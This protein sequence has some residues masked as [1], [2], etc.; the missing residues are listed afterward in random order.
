MN[1]RNNFDFMRF[2]AATLVVFSHSFPLIGKFDQE[3]FMRWSGHFGGGALGVAIFF[4]MSGYLVTASRQ[5]SANALQFLLKRALR[6]FPALAVVVLLSVFVLGP[7]LTTLPLGTYLLH[8][9]TRGY[10]WNI[11]L[12]LHFTLPGVFSG[13]P[14]SGPVNGSLWTLPIEA[15]MYVAVA[16]LG[17]IGL[18]RRQWLSIGLVALVAL[19]A[20]VLS[21]QEMQKIGLLKEFIKFGIYFFIGAT[22]YVF[23]RMIPWRAWIAALLLIGWIASFHTPY[24]AYCMF[25]A[26]SYCTL[27]IARSSWPPLANFGRYGDFSYGIYIYSFPVQQTLVQLFGPTNLSPLQLFFM[28]QAI[29]LTCAA[30][31]W[32]LIEKPALRLKRRLPAPATGA[33]AA[34]ASLPD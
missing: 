16:I 24:G 33:P 17:A 18:L 29:A 30:I 25:V 8:P 22:L 28:A 23:D 21:D 2:V 20:Y 6:I 32:H 34:T 12:W 14:Y 3:P 19:Y 7:L 26:V 13:L 4:V 10:L 11:A 1:R 15:S 31:S 5:N 27:Y 9:G